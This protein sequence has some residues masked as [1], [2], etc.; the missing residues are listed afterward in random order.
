MSPRGYSTAFS[1]PKPAYFFKVSCSSGVIFRFPSH[2]KASR[3]AAILSFSFWAA[4]KPT[5]FLPEVIRDGT[6]HRITQQTAVFT[7]R[8]AQLLHYRRTH[9]HQV[10]QL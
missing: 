8:K 6:Y 2:S 10:Q 5:F 3:I 7:C 9:A 1:P 4:L